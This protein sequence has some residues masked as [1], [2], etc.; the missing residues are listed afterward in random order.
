MISQAK[1]T[2]KG[3]LAEQQADAAWRRLHQ[4][5]PRCQQGEIIAAKIKQTG[6]HIFVCAECETTWFSHDQIGSTPFL[7]FGTYMKQLGLPPLWDELIE[8]SSRDVPP[9]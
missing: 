8:I 6:Q 7:D 9:A 4:T 1:P 5:C 2:S 3:A